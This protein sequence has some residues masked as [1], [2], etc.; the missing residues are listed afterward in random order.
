MRCMVI[1]LALVLGGCGGNET[2][3]MTC[4]E[5]NHTENLYSTY[6]METV[7]AAM[8]FCFISGKGL[9]EDVVTLEVLSDD[10]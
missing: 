10:D 9:A 3:S 5:F 7:E 8:D 6:T 4:N 1:I 2:V